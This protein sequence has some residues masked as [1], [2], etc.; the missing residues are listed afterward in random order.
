MERYNYELLRQSLLA[1]LTEE[2]W[3]KMPFKRQHVAKAE[4]LGVPLSQLRRLVALVGPDERLDPAW[5]ASLAEAIAKEGID[6]HDQMDHV[7]L[8][9]QYEATDVDPLTQ[10]PKFVPEIEGAVVLHL[11]NRKMAQ[12]A[13]AAFFDAGRPP[14]LVYRRHF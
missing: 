11:H 9:K 4:V 10:E 1:K 5:V 13:G 2:D 3:M 8:L 7:L 6:D 14:K 12:I